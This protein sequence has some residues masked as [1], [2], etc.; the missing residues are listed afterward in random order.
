LEN[1]KNEKTETMEMGDQH[2]ERKRQMAV[3]FWAYKSVY[4][5]E[6]LY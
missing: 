6:R 5:V 2:G 4:T 1:F 3:V